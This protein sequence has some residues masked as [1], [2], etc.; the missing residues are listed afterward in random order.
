MKVIV[1]ST[2]PVLDSQERKKREKEVKNALKKLC[3]TMN[4]REK[5]SDTVRQ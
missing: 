4:R 5:S 1:T 3:V 2:H